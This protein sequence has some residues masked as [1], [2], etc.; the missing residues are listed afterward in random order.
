MRCDRCDRLTTSHV[1][2]AFVLTDLK[3]CHELFMQNME[4]FMVSEPFDQNACGRLL[5]YT[6]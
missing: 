2:Y 1:Q 3:V 5:L 4:Q 6:V